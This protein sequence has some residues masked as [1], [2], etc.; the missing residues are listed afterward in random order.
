MAD[1]II[2]DDPNLQKYLLE[3]Y[4]IQSLLIPH[5]ADR[6]AHL[7]IK[8]NKLEDF[9][10]LKEKFALFFSEISP[11]NQAELV[12]KAFAQYPKYHLVMVG[13]WPQ[14]KKSRALKKHFE[15]YE[16]IHFLAPKLD[17]SFLSLLLDKAHIYLHSYEGWGA[18]LSL[19]E[20]LARQLPAF[21]FDLNSLNES[22]PEGV[23]FYRHS[24]H[25]IDQL[26]ELPRE[27]G[28]QGQHIQSPT[29]WQQIARQF[30][31]AFQAC[32]IDSKLQEAISSLTLQESPLT[33]GNSTAISNKS[34]AE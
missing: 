6:V 10:F 7:I 13:N 27:K 23:R 29:S 19:K 5:G 34:S 28:I 30:D 9:P 8:E 17:P 15:P 20:A 26:I 24:S 3:Q 33:V 11:V 1:L 16:N 18:N 32:L 22:R 21:A 12:L 25:L 31:S 4:K 2:V 14:N